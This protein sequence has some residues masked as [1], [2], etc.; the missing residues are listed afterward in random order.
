MPGGRTRRVLALWRHVWIQWSFAIGRRLKLRLASLF[1]ARAP[2]RP[3]V[4]VKQAIAS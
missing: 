4:V 3:A 2:R 1:K